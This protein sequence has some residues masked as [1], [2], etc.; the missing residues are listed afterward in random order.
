MSLRVGILG[1]ARVATYAMIAAARDVDGVTVAGVAARDPARARSYAD[2]HGIAQVYESYEA[3][4]A[5]DHIDAIYNALPPSL[6]ARWSIAALCAGKP[7]LCEKPFAL[8][9]DDV[10]AMLAAEAETGQVLMEAQHSHYHPLSARMRDIVRSGVLGDIVSADACFDIVVERRPDELRFLPDVGGGALWD[11][12]IYPAYWLCSTL[13]W[14][15]DLLSAQQR[16]ADT[17]ADIASEARLRFGANVEATISCDMAAPLRVYAEFKGSKGSLKVRNP[18]AP[19]HGHALELTVNGVATQ[20]HFS[21]RTSYAYQLEA[22]RDAV[23]K[24]AAVQTGGANSLA[25]ITLLSAIRDYA[26]RQGS[27]HAD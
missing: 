4:I 19:Q 1:A 13:G 5:D 12:G 22:F 27:S 2:S 11:L 21:T 25:V 15:P 14:Q 10:K 23:L 24:S 16:R 26:T 17:G 7:V 3:L 6:H 18:L 20:E 9:V 8:C